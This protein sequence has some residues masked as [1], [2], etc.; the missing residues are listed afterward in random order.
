MNRKRMNSA[1]AVMAITA[2]TA[3]TLGAWQQDRTRQGT[4]PG[5]ATTTTTTTT[6]Q[7][8]RMQPGNRTGQLRTGTNT[9]ATD[10][11]SA[12]KII[13]SDIAD[14]NNDSV[15]TIDDLV[16][17][18]GSGQVT[19]VVVKSGSILGLGGKSVLIPYRE[20]QWDPSK[21]RLMLGYEHVSDFPAYTSESWK[22]LRSSSRPADTSW[23]QNRTNRAMQGQGHEQPDAGDRARTG[24]GMDNRN[25]DNRNGTNPNYNNRNPGATNPNTNTNT[26]NT[27]GSDA[28]SN[29]GTPRM[30]TGSGTSDNSQPRDMN[31][32][33]NEPRATQTGEGATKSPTDRDP[34]G[35]SPRQQMTSGST[36]DQ[37]G[38]N[39]W[40]W[41][42]SQYGTNDPYS[43]MWTSGTSQRIEGEVKSVNREFIPGQG[44]QVVLEVQ[45]TDGNTKKVALGPSWYVNGGDHGLVRGEKVSIEAMPVYI[46]TSAQVN[47]KDM[48]LRDD[49]GRG[50]W[51]GDTFQYG[52]ANYSAPSYR[53]V[54]LSELRGATLDCRGSNCGKVDDV[55]L[56]MNSGMAAFLSIDPN[57]NFLG[58]GDTKR[59]A[60]WSVV[61]IAPDGKV[62]VDA[63]KE[64]MTNAM[65]TP[66]DVT[67]LNQGQTDS[68]YNAYQVQPRDYNRWREDDNRYDYRWRRDRDQG[69][70]YDNSSNGTSTQGN[71]S[72]S[73]TTTTPR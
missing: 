58:I 15:G 13:G 20:F 73:T 18:R 38:L 70:R 3:V 26:N 30:N 68:I 32:P 27:P 61:S 46:A 60:P 12:H 37:P 41:R 42:Q 54:L 72:G 63:Q 43:T 67:T 35:A 23:D 49:T 14:Y 4:Q 59:L 39:D 24:T 65:V 44:E 17:D 34:N 10:Y 53:N 1:V 50:T 22:S 55:I 40:M 52:G 36:E 8:G 11:R 57:Q 56:E 6:D 66:S 45:T 69:R 31:R 71:P 21:A 64:M 7:N 25:G 51:S 47:G 28:G 9:F 16:I 19:H 33:A 2:G 48:R 62:R 5:S 29:T